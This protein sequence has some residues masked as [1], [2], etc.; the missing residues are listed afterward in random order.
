MEHTYL[1]NST[2]GLPLSLTL[3]QRLRHIAVNGK[4]GY[5]KSTA[6]KS[7][8]AQDIARG[9][10]VLLLDPAGTLAEEVLALIP[11]SRYTFPFRKTA[12]KQSRSHY[13]R[14]RE[15]IE[16]IITQALLSL[17]KPDTRPSK[18]KSRPRGQH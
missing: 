17:T 6:L 12:R 9:D 8:I 13:G 11:P 2:S 5:G 14:A 7:V 4:T 15:K 10:G 18:R 1:G 3:E 16:P